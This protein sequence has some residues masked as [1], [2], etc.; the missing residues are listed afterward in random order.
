VTVPGS[1]SR[2]TIYDVARRANVSKSLVS[3]VMQGSPNVS[4]KRRAA[5]LAAIEELG[6]APSRAAATLAGSRSRGIGVVIDDYR[7]MWFVDL[8]DGL[9]SVLD[10]LGYTVTVSDRHP[11]GPGGPDA[12]TGFLSMNVE[13]IVVATEPEGLR[14]GHVAIPLVVAGGRQTSPASA[15][16]V[17]NDD[18]HGAKLALTHL[19]ELGHTRIGHL[20]GEG[21]SAGRRRIAF[22]SIM[23]ARGLP[24][25][26]FGAGRPTSEEDGYIDA[27]ELLEAHP[28][29]TAI[30]SAN[31]TMAFGALAALR[32]RGRSVP[33]DISLI[34]YDNSPLAA[35]KYVDLTTIDAR[36]VAVGAEVARALIARIDNPLLVQRTTLIAPRLIVRT[37]TA[38]PP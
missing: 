18:A 37:S 9:R 22:E 5:V 15:D 1:A 23:G 16:V 20:T 12:V 21:G 35:S 38:P 11:T 32:E 17:A 10:G 6:Y 30:F 7:N 4:D 19:F 13:G 36:S 34:G 24:A 29:T 14:L 27:H 25:P 8:L 2:P 28:E 26:M 3:L 33:G 31:D